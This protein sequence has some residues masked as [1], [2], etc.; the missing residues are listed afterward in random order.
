MADWGPSISSNLHTSEQVSSRPELT[1]AYQYL[2]LQVQV[3]GDPPLSCLILERCNSRDVCFT[4]WWTPYVCCLSVTEVVL[5]LVEKAYTL[6]IIIRMT[7]VNYWIG[8]IVAVVEEEPLQK[9]WNR[10]EDRLMK[11]P[12]EESQPQILEKKGWS[13]YWRTSMW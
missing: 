6:A 8:Q 3:V 1:P 7:R 10:P 9:R 4:N 5:E 11:G 2:Y 13:E 12:W